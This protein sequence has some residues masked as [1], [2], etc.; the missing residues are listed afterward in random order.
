MI[1]NNANVSH[2]NRHIESPCH[3][4]P[5]YSH[6]TVHP[7]P[8]PQRVFVLSSRH[9]PSLGR[10]G[11]LCLESRVM[12]G[13]RLCMYRL[14]D[15]FAQQSVILLAKLPVQNQNSYMLIDQENADI[16]PLRC[17]S[18]KCFLNSC[19]V[20]LAIHDEEVLLGIWRLRDMLNAR[21]LPAMYNPRIEASYTYTC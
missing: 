3:Q 11:D 10:K 17:E 1:A 7:P 18:F 4:P 19:I 15:G 12:L 5:K 14:D 8:T 13:R 9:C 21:Q 16:L 2:S 20:G 6:S